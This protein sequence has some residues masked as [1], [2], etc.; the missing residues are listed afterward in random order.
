MGGACVKMIIVTFFFVM[1]G[2]LKV[3]VY[4]AVFVS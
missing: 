3:F 1:A 4:G 2:F